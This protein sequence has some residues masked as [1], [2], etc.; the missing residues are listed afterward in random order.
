[1]PKTFLIGRTKTGAIVA[2]ASGSDYGY[3]HAATS[4][5]YVRG[6]VI[7]TSGA[8]FS[9]SAHGATKAWASAY[10]RGPCEIV[11]LEKVDAKTYRAL[12]GKS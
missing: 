7:P 8:N 12:T 5:D 6:H 3:T 10:N 4:P 1:M 11:E 2:R 9:R